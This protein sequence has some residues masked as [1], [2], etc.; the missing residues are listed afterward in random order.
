[1]TLRPPFVY[2]PN[3]E[4]LQPIM[5]EI[6]LGNM[7]FKLRCT[8]EA[9][10]RGKAQRLYAIFRWYKAQFKAQNLAP[11]EFPELNI[12]PAAEGPIWYVY[13][14][15]KA[16]I[17]TMVTKDGQKVEIKSG[18]QNWNYDDVREVREDD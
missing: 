14:K 15:D 17:C 13:I 16:N 18:P 12:R 11:P 3:T 7:P 8:D 6:K 5:E 9:Q 2:D 10:A 1:M 4:P